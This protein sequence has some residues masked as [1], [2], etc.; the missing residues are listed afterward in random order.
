[1]S[2]L[3]AEGPLRRVGQQLE[4]QCAVKSSPMTTSVTSPIRPRRFAGGV[5]AKYFEWPNASLSGS[6]AGV[7]YVL[8]APVGVLTL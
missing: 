7:R 6:A 3:L 8:G 2:G 4:P 5:S 1:M